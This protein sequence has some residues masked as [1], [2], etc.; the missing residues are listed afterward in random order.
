MAEIGTAVTLQ[1]LSRRLDPNNKV[2]KI[3]EVLNKR[4]EILDDIQWMEGNLPTGHTT[5]IRTGLPTG[6][7][8]KLNYGVP[9]EK[10]T[11]Q[12]IT[13]TCG[14]LETYCEVDKD[15]VELNRN[16][17]AFLL[18]ENKSFIEGMGQ[19]LATTLFYGDTDTNPER[20]LGF[21]PR[22]NL[23]STDE[24]NSGY[25]IITAGGSG[26][27]NTSIWL[28]VWGEDTVHGIYPQGSV[29]G[30]KME[31]L[32]QDT[33]VDSNGYKHEVIRTH[34]QWKCGLTVRNWRSVA[35]IANIDWSDLQ[36]AGDTSDTS[37][38][39]IKYM[40]QAIDKVE[41]FIP[42]GKAVFYMRPDVKTML[43]EKLMD[44]GF[45]QLS[46]GELQG[47]QN[48]MSF[49]GIPVRSCRAI[50]KAESVIS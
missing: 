3:I 32:G 40:N 46:F 45:A 13:D 17:E 23:I 48:V 7:W 21:A 8:R 26:S 12:Q 15:L 44:K 20:F 35:R 36:T 18:S 27:D 47:R 24:D 22:Y 25:N 11:T 6:A 2:A 4:N 41:E 37:A 38:N 29:A 19:T 16:T 43:R 9:Q 33:S 31:N 5:T 28:V 39:I 42:G 30:L 50:T 49:N 10:S 34:Y 14:M 1:D